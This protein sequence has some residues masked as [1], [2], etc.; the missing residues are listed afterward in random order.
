[1][2]FAITSVVCLVDA[3]ALIFVLAGCN[4]AFKIHQIALVKILFRDFG[5]LVPQ[6]DSVPLRAFYFLAFA[7]L[8]SLVS[9]NAEISDLL[10]TT[11]ATNLGVTPKLPTSIALFTD[12]VVTLRC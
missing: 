1:M 10:A 4:L 2:T 11:C 8:V 7:V 5:K 3:I 12:I 9:R 6:H